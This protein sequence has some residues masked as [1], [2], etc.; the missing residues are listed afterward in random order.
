MPFYYYNNSLDNHG[1]HEVHTKDCDYLEPLS[2]RTMIG[3]ENNCHDAIRR[4]RRE[5]G[6]QNFDGC[7]WC[8]RDC[9]EG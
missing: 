5:T 9:H 1:N 2:N 3:L 8:S 6:K 7:F 4:A